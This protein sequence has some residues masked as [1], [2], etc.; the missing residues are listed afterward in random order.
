MGIA[1]NQDFIIAPGYSARWDADDC[2]VFNLEVRNPTHRNGAP[3]GSREWIFS[4]ESWDEFVGLARQVEEAL[5]IA[6]QGV[7]KLDGNFARL[8]TTDGEADPR[9][10]PAYKV[11]ASPEGQPGASFRFYGPD[12]VQAI[13]IAQRECRT[14]VARF[15]NGLNGT[16]GL[17]EYRFPEA[18]SGAAAA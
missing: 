7:F 4:A 10:A 14:E 11:I 13:W 6:A 9:G 17:D 3:Y 12:P 2:G 16:I 1:R 18:S 8:D 5:K 15:Q